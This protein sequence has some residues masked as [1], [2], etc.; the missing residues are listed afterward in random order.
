MRPWYVA[1]FETTTKSFYEKYGYVKVWLFAICDSDSNVVC[2][3]ETI[4]EFMEWCYNHPKCD[5]YFHNLRFDGSFILSYILDNKWVCKEFSPFVW[6]NTYNTLISDDGV[7]YNINLNF[8]TEH[9]VAIYD[10]AKIIPLKVR[11]IAKAFKLQIEKEI[12]DYDVYEVNEKTISYVSR[13]VQIVAQALRYFKDQGFNRMTI[14]SIAFNECKKGIKAFKGL[15]PELS[16]EFLVEWRKAYRGGRTQVNPMYAGQ[17]LNGVHRFDINSMYPYVLSRMPMPYGKPI[18]INNMGNYEFEIYDVHIMFKLKD[19][20]IPTLLKSASMYAKDNDTYYIE[21]EGIEH[22]YITSVDYEILQRHYDIQYIKFIKGYG[23]KT[24]T[25]IFRDIIDKFYALKSEST[26][27]MRLLWKL[28]LN[29]IYGKFGSKPVGKNKYPE[30]DNDGVLQFFTSEEHDMPFYYLP[31]AMAVTSFAHKLIDDAI[32][33]VGFENFIYCD[34]DS[35]HTFKMLPIEW[36]D[37]KE[38]GKFK[39]E[40]YEETS[41]Y[42]RQKCYCYSER[43]DGTLKYTIT[44]AGMTDS[45]KDYLIKTYGGNVFDIFGIGLHI[46]EATEGITLEDLKLKPKRVQGGVVLMPTPFSLL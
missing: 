36:I 11:E 38:I 6:C 12:I 28:I 15:F 24:S 8:D 35:V 18:L 25:K 45:I 26:G 4:E 14:G 23:F 30:L 3:G 31:V 10:S 21:T 37:N 44:C 22:I 1:D 40:G 13:D 43:I 27:G 7:W 20:H 39:Y 17:V 32:C 33:E 16:K 9:E 34:T 41:K 5:I 46:S 2:I 42:I 29:N 19:G